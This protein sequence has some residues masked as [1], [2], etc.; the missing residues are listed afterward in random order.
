MSSTAE[1]PKQLLCVVAPCYDEEQVVAAFHGRLKAVL[2]SLSDL[3]HRIVFVDDGSRDGTLE[4]LGE[5]AESDERVQVLALSRNFGHQAALSAGLAVAKGDAV[6]FLDS[7]LQHP[8]ELIT[9]MVERWRDGHDVVSAVRRRTADAPL[10]K[11]LGSRL[12]YWLIRRLSDTPIVP[13]AADYCLL[14]RRAHGALLRMPERHRFLRGMVSW[15]GFP[16][17][18]VHYDAAARPAGASK[19]DLRR[20]FRLAVD[21]VFSFSVTPIRLMIRFGVVITLL[22]FSY[23]GYVL[24]RAVLLDDLVQGWGS[25]ISVVL[26]LGGLQLLFM[27][28]IG[29]YLARVFEEVKQR[30]LYVLKEPS[31][32]PGPGADDDAGGSGDPS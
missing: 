29:E 5:L 22:G 28:M 24:L 32:R 11:N 6:V 16:R 3:D 4:R 7:D 26:I 25:L 10:L 12:F 19:S 17:A 18:L 2:T 8:P 9:D 20:M 14:S 15:I 30:P 31:T 27:G 13:G 21:A 1:R 23:L